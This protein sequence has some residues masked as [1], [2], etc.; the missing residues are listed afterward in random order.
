[1][2]D[3][4]IIDTSDDTYVIPGD[5]YFP[6]DRRAIADDWRVCDFAAA[7]WRIAGILGLHALGLIGHAVSAGELSRVI[8]GLHLIEITPGGIRVGG[9]RVWNPE[10]DAL[11]PVT[12]L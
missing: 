2:R 7:E 8:L 3:D 12:I 9:S 10:T 5:V 1:M 11:K 6:E 4:D